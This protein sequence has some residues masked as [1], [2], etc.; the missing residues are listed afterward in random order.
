MRLYKIT[1]NQKFKIHYAELLFAPIVQV[2]Q[3]HTSVF[4]S[5]PLRYLRGWQTSFPRFSQS[6]LKRFLKQPVLVVS[7][8]VSQQLDVAET[9]E[10]NANNKCRSWERIQPASLE[11]NY[12]SDYFLL[13]RVSELRF[14]A[15][16]RRHFV[17]H[18]VDS[19][20]NKHLF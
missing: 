2:I 6:K 3:A 11:Y 9:V 17:V 4:L 20:P 15:V 18:V 1:C 8:N 12:S 14:R 10:C 19:A 7:A 13:C 5:V 16:C